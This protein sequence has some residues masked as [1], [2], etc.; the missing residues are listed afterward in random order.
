M[1]DR[2]PTRIVGD[3]PAAV[4]EFGSHEPVANA[5]CDLLETEPGGRTIGLEGGWGSGKSTVA[6]LLAASPLEYLERLRL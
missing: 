5:I 1:A 6:K 4:D 2:C 3:A